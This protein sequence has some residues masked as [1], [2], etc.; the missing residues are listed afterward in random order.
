MRFIKW[1]MVHIFYLSLKSMSWKTFLLCNEIVLVIWVLKRRIPKFKWITSSF[2]T[3][4]RGFGFS[5]SKHIRNNRSKVRFG[6]DNFFI[7]CDC[8]SRYRLLKLNL[9]A[10]VCK[11]SETLVP[12]VNSKSGKRSQNFMIVN[13]LLKV[14]EAASVPTSEVNE[15]LESNLFVPSNF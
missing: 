7:L 11:L 12:N 8:V 9:C 3:H 1:Y 2:Q 10:G 14:Q 6:I 15:L 4:G 13:L 5:T